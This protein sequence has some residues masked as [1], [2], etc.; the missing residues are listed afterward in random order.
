[1]IE[2]MV[3]ILNPSLRSRVNYVKNHSWESM[4]RKRILHCVQNDKGKRVH[5][6]LTTHQAMWGNNV[7]SIDNRDALMLAY[8]GS[9]KCAPRLWIASWSFRRGGILYA[10]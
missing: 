8:G 3:V 9:G 6:P 1:M 7:K 2:A 10:A 5:R 4:L